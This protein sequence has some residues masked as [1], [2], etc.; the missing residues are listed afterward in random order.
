MDI[1]SA[2]RHVTE[3]DNLSRSDM[4]TVM[5]SIMTG[6]CSPAQIAGFLIVQNCLELELVGYAGW[7]VRLIRDHLRRMHLS[8]A[9]SDRP[10]VNA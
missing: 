1:Q 9:L 10:G 6:Q 8:S 3:K 7:S 4:R 5:N 2:I